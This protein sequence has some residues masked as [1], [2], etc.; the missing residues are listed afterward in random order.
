[1]NEIPDYA[2]LT[3]IYLAPDLFFYFKSKGIKLTMNEPKNNFISFI[4]SIKNCISMPFQQTFV[5]SAVEKSREVQW[6][7]PC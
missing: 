5:Y 3:A 2:L 7:N 6:H 1:M 4:R